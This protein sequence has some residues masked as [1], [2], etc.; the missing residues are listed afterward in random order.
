[1]KKSQQ[2]K[3]LEY[4]QKKGSISVVEAKRMRI[5]RLSSYINRLRKLGYDIESIRHGIYD[6]YYRLNKE[7]K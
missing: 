6:S 4:L 1:M 2:Q 7:I 5:S 3:V